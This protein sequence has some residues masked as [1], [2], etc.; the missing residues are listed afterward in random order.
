MVGRRRY[1]ILVD[2]NYQST[3][4]NFMPS[5]G[6]VG[7]AMGR[8]NLQVGFGYCVHDLPK[9]SRYVPTHLRRYLSYWYLPIPDP[10]LSWH[11]M[12]QL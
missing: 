8:V 2:I 6:P 5:A 7:H 12:S 11:V 9:V 1:S 10:V 4:C 3:Y